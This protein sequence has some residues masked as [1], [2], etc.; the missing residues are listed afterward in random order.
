MDYRMEH[1][2]TLQLVSDW[3]QR[4]G[5]KHCLLCVNQSL[6]CRSVHCVLKVQDR[7]SVCTKVEL[8]CHGFGISADTI[9]TIYD[10][11]ITVKSS[12]ICG[13]SKHGLFNVRQTNQC[14]KSTP[15][16]INSEYAFGSANVTQL[17]LLKL[18]DT[19]NGDMKILPKLSGL[20]V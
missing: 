15:V 12:L 4:G 13:H 1:S 10:S 11:H 6:V 7:T 20:Y 17:L 9:S 2:P 19:A 18:S 8:V 16:V 5:E 3:R 14:N